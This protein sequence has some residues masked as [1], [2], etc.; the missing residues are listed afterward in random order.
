MGCSIPQA[1]KFSFMTVHNAMDV[2][3]RRLH[4]DRDD[5]E[6]LPEDTIDGPTRMG[7]MIEALHRLCPELPTPSCMYRSLP[8]RYPS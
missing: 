6:S 3:L 4:L 8:K 1:Y 7:A 2:K 5:T